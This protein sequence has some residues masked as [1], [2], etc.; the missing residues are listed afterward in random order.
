MTS[1]SSA[2][3]CTADGKTS[4]DDCPMFTSSLAWTASPASVAITSLAFMFDD[5]P[6]PV[7][8]TSIGN[9]SSSSPAAMR[10]PGGRD[11]R[12]LLGVEQAELGVHAG[13]GR[14]DPAQP[15]RHGCG[16][17][18]ARDRKVRDRLGG[19]AAPEVLPLLGPGHGPSLA[20]HCAQVAP[21]HGTVPQQPPGALGQ[22]GARCP[23]DVPAARALR[24]AAARLGLAYRPTVPAV[25]ALDLPET[26]LHATWI[27]VAAPCECPPFEGWRVRLQPDPAFGRHRRKARGQAEA[28]PFSASGIEQLAPCAPA[29]LW[30]GPAARRGRAPRSRSPPS[31]HR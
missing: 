1:S 7:W 27:G 18:L 29:S 13:G 24:L 16:N 17:R 19:L 14:L 8:K 3:R 11:P 12:R 26:D 25:E 28:C 10:S 31:R 20:S 21:L 9:W 5:V 22:L 4:F 15:A 2:A 30:D 6:E 23:A